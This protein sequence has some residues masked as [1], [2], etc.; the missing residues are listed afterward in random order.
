M[1][2]SQPPWGCRECPFCRALADGSTILML[3][4]GRNVVRPLMLDW[5]IDSAFLVCHL[6][7]G[8][9]N[10]QGDY[11][12]TLQVVQELLN[13]FVYI[14]DYVIYNVTYFAFVP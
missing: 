4:D 7:D 11:V 6:P 10:V 3:R 1:F 9:R 5:G 8:H 14:Y 12:E 13:R 2:K